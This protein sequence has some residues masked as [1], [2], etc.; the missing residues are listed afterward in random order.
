MYTFEFLQHL[1]DHTNFSID[2]GSVK[3]ELKDILDGQ[4]MQIMAEWG[5]QKLWS[6]DLW[7]ECLIKD[8]SKY[9]KSCP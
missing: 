4:P 8:A 1:F 6:F 5:G 9:V 3:V 2:I 7:N